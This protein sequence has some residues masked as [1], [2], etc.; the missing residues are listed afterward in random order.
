MR[1]Y[2]RH[3]QAAAQRFALLGFTLVELLVVIGII[4]LLISI[5]LPT[6]GRARAQAKSVQCMSNLRQIGVGIEIYA[7]SSKDEWLPI[8]FWNGNFPGAG[9]FGGTQPPPG[10]NQND[11]AT[12]WDMQVMHALSSKYGDNWNSAASA[13]GQPNA[14]TAKLKSLFRCPDAP[15]YNMDA[16]QNSADT[17]YMTNPRL[18]PDVQNIGGISSPTS[19]GKGKLTLAYR[20][21]II[22][23]SS[24]IAM[25]FDGVVNWSST[26]N[27]WAAGGGFQD[28]VA[29]SI[30]NQGIFGPLHLL[31]IYGDSRFDQTHSIDMTPNGG[32][33]LYVNQDTQ[34]NSQNSLNVRFRHMHDTTANALMVDGHVESF[35]YDKS[36]P[37]NDPKVT[38]F[39]RKNLY[40]N[41]WGPDAYTQ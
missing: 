16:P 20:L 32:N 3:G 28:P 22:K 9:A 26:Y 6:L 2:S 21:S 14:N 33:V 35:K 11:H 29:D 4:A 37:A 8:G 30:D 1:N 19:P 18:I 12:H 25:V 23:H 13:Q 39:L 34:D 27:S 24:D 36:K 41:P 17:D 15:N 40:V 38:S 31:A 5:L 10:W 7:L